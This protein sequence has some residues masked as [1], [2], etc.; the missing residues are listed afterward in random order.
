[1]NEGFAGLERVINDRIKILGL[2]LFIYFIL[3]I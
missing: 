1:M 2:Y 3:F